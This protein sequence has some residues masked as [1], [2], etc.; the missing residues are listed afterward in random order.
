L[1]GEGKTK[2]GFKLSELPTSDEKKAL[3]LTST[4][5]TTQS[6]LSQFLLAKTEIQVE[7]FLTNKPQ[8]KLD[9]AVEKKFLETKQLAK[10]FNKKG[11]KR[12]IFPLFFPESSESDITGSL[13]ELELTIK[14]RNERILNF[15][16]Y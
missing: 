4:S 12:F 14:Q 13:D 3:V 16:Q 6:A 2:V 8:L 7:Q 15:A 5:Q 1:V 9:Q 10:E 11:Q